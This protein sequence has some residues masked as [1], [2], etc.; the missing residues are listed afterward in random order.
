MKVHY[1]YEELVNGLRQIGL[2]AGDIVF[3]HSNIG[4]LGFSDRGS[5]QQDIFKTVFDAFQEIL[6]PEGTLIVPSFTYSFGRGDVFDLQNT[7]SQMGVFAET[8]RS[9]PGALRSEDPM[10]SVVALGAHAEYLTKDVSDIC[11][12]DDSFWDRF[13]KLG[14]KIC[15]VGVFGGASTF[16][17]YVEKKL[18]VPYR[19]DKLFPGSIRVNGISRRKDMIF[20]CQDMSNTATR[21]N[22]DIFN[23]IGI[24]QG[25]IK[26]IKIG[27]GNLY[28]ITADE[29]YQF[30]E[31]TIKDKPY[32]L[33]EAY[34]SGVEPVLIKRDLPLIEKPLSSIERMD[35]MIQAVWRCK[36]D[37]V[38]DGIEDALSILNLCIPM[39]IHEY[40][41]GSHTANGIIPEKWICKEAYLE[42]TSGERIF[43]YAE[44]NLHLASYSQSFSGIVSASV[45]F[46]HL[47][48][49]PFLDDAIPYKNLY[50]TRDWKLCC[51]KQLK[52][53][54][55]EAE[56]KVH[57]NSGFSFGSLKVGEV[58]IKGESNECIVIAG[59]LDKTMQIN[60]GLSGVVAG[61]QIMKN[62]SKNKNLKYSYRLL[63]CPEKIGVSAF[64][65]ENFQI[66]ADVKVFIELDLLGI[67]GKQPILSILKHKE[68]DSN[69]LNDFLEAVIKCN[70]LKCSVVDVKDRPPLFKFPICTVSGISQH[71]KS[72]IL[73][74]FP[75][76]KSDKDN[77]ALFDLQQSEDS[78]T[79]ILSLI[80]TLETDQNHKQPKP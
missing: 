71:N 30:I 18:N 23:R 12:G 45:L 65:N 33:T 42:T 29:T 4:I 26:T 55:S 5:A 34:N 7:P 44:N 75:S 25:V 77:L 62:L 14:G 79:R 19:Y 39:N 49:H 50:G 15:N 6:Q 54:L 43:S 16:L 56:Y 57:I 21:V 11:F 80:E 78:V 72:E 73:E 22:I 9:M 10:F 53:A 63:I 32:F 67:E 69:K 46:E 36:R 3:T 38:S 31:Q 27:R 47:E 52:N 64:F 40:P 37:I 74:N 35:E 1:T 76:F 48:T 70:I 2:G 8:I 28:S 61:I 58:F 51:S 41:T 17:H 66:L 59:Y 68:T 20:F 13:Y 60:Y 24:E